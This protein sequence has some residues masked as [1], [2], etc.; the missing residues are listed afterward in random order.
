LLAQPVLRALLVA[1]HT[2]CSQDRNGLTNTRTTLTWLPIRLLMWNMPP[3]SS[4]ICTQFRFIACPPCIEKCA[5]GRR[6][7]RAGRAARAPKVL[8]LC[9]PEK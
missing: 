2:G 7:R 9:R 5:P 1:E 3:T 4:I 6:S 8:P